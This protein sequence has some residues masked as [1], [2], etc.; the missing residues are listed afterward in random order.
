MDLGLPYGNRVVRNVSAGGTFLDLSEGMNFSQVSV[1][2]NVVADSLL[3]VYT[4]KWTPD[5]DPYHIGYA[6]THDRG[7]SAIARALKQR[8]NLLGSPRLANPGRGDFRLL[9]DSPAWKAG[10]RTI[11]IDSIGLVVDEFRKSVPPPS[12]GVR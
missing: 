7:D 8:A 10:F 1:E 6:S 12:D 4:K 2:N 11:P 3:L 5:Y 9:E